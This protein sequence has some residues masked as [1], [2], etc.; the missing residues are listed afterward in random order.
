MERGKSGWLSHSLSRVV[1]HIADDPY[2]RPLSAP[3]VDHGTDGFTGVGMLGPVLPGDT[4][5]DD[6]DPRGLRVVT[7]VQRPPG[8]DRYTDGLEVSRADEMVPER[9]QQAR[10]RS[11][12][13]NFKL[14]VLIKTGPW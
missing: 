11:E 2:D 6:D 12:S 10:G 8:F 3:K 4:R 5:V 7:F 14:R 13:L 9:E 1:R